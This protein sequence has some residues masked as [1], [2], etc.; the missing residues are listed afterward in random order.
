MLTVRRQACSGFAAS[1]SLRELLSAAAPQLSWALSA[2]EVTGDQA[3]S[4]S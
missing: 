3:V 4:A 2:Q 1:S